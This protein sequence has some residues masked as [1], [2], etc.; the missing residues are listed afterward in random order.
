MSTESAES[1]LSW[2]EGGTMK[3]TVVSALAAGP[4]LAPGDVTVR[5]ERIE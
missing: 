2:G 5:I 1:P 4:A 3:K